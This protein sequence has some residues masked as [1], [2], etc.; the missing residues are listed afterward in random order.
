VRPLVQWDEDEQRFKVNEGGRAPRQ[1]RGRGGRGAGVG[2]G[3]GQP[4]SSGEEGGKAS[5]Q[6]GS[7][8]AS[9]PQLGAGT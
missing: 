7:R 2:R 6:T 3:R 4:Q 9:A 1:L 8:A 5:Q